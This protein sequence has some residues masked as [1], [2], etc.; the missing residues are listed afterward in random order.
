MKSYKYE[1]TPASP[2]HRRNPRGRNL[3]VPLATAVS[4]TVLLG[5]LG[6]GFLRLDVTQ[7]LGAWM[8]GRPA[9]AD[10]RVLESAAL[11]AQGDGH[12][13]RYEPRAAEMRYAEALQ[14]AP[15]RLEA[16]D[17]LAVATFLQPDGKSPTPAA[18]LPDAGAQARLLL[19]LARRELLR[20]RPQQALLHLDA[21]AQLVPEQPGLQE[22]YAQAYRL[23]GQYPAAAIA[24]EKAR[25]QNP[26]SAE[27]LAFWFDIQ[28]SA[29]HADRAV[30]AALTAYRGLLSGPDLA[31]AL[32]GLARI[33]LHQGLG[34][35]ELRRQLAKDAPTLA[36]SARQLTMARAY[37]YHYKANPNWNRDSFERVRELVARL[38]HPHSVASPAE[39]Q[40]ALQIMLE[41]HAARV[42]RWVDRSDM[43][44]ARNEVARAL[45]LLEGAPQDRAK[46]AD[47]F[48]QHARFCTLTG[49]LED[50]T[51]SLE[52]AVRLVPEHPARVEL[53]RMQAELGV[54]LLSAGQRQAAIGHLR[55][56]VQ[57]HPEDDGLLAR[58]YQVLQ[59][60]SPLKAALTCARLVKEPELGAV[61]GRLAHGLAQAGKKQEAASL[62]KLAD[63]F[64]LGVGRRAELRAELAR[65]S[66]KL[67]LAR[68]ALLQALEYGPQASLWLRLATVEA[69]LAVTAQ[70]R[71][72]RAVTHLEAALDAT[73]H[74]LALEP[75]GPASERAI[76][77]SRD[78]AAALLAQRQASRAERVAQIATWLA[79]SHPQL[80]L[81]LA[82]ARLAANHPAQ[83]LDA[84]LAGLS[85]TA[86]PADAP[87]A[88]LRLRQGRALRQLGR[89][90]EAI[91]AL[92]E[93][94]SDA[95]AAKPVVVADAWFELTFAHAA[96]NQREEA[97]NAAR[98]YVAASQYDPRRG[99]RAADVKRIELAMRQTR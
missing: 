39:R 25:E 6:W 51:R 80:S 33:Y 90:G 49:R 22:A 26:Q 16:W 62:V 10:E 66:G 72:I 65:A 74:A 30:P 11:L 4:L 97:L 44:G 12:L 21:A 24:A 8:F 87:Y 41:A 19:A 7:R 85:G 61:L 76:Q 18:Y 68:Q 38:R 36:S 28:V 48:A 46:K 47:L 81:V 99:G 64:R 17:R 20:T 56:A 15:E 32:S 89:H 91:A 78:L 42:Q 96:L 63:A 88:P 57:L 79:P 29:G 73:R 40:D 27:T 53:A 69:Q 92:A 58:L 75:T 94:L 35:E 3:R 83:A 1:A 67:G 71:G 60:A 34:L 50:A 84:C 82:D 59:P 55:R 52:S 5:G 70:H 54:T 31:G 37:L 23:S 45:K 2:L 14:R 77:I 93:A 43:E 9:V 98:Q 86:Q 13:V 95:A